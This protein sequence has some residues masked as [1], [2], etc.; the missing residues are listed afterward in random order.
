MEKA[1]GN[2]ICNQLIKQK[3]DLGLENQRI[4]HQINK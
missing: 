4:R 1:K 3:I 2:Q